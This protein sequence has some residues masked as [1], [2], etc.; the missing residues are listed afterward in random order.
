MK[1]R[2]SV[3]FA[4]VLF[5]LTAVLRADVRLAAPFGSNAVIQ[6]DK[7]IPV[8]GAADAGEKVTVQFGRRTAS[9]TTG[10]DGRWR[11]TLDALPASDKPAELIITGKNQVVFTN[12]LVGDVWLCGGQSNMEWN[13]ARTDNAAA[14]IAAA[15][16]PGIRYIKIDR[17]IASAPAA[18]ATG[19]WRLCTPRE[20]GPCSAVAYFFAR[21]INRET[22]VPIGIIQ[23]S[24]SGAMIESYMPPATLAAPAFPN[25]AA[26]WKQT[27]AAYPRNKEKYDADRAAWEKE[28]DAAAEKNSPFKKPAPREPVGI[29]H[30]DE[31][32]G[33]YN[34]MVAPLAPAGLRG[35]LWY[36]GEGNALRF[37]EYREL[38]ATMI[39]SWRATFAQGDLPFYWVQLPNYKAG[40]GTARARAFLREAQDQTLA[41]P[42]TGQA[43]TIDVGNPDDEHPT[44]KQEVGRRL[45]L[46]ALTKQYGKS[47]A[48]ENPRFVSARA[49]GSAM[50]VT[51]AHASGL[52]LRGTAAPA[53][54]VAGAD[55]VFRSATARIET[56]SGGV[57][58]LVSS[59]EVAAP[60]AVRYAWFN[61][62][63]ANLHNAAGLP[64]TPF[65]SDDWEA[66]DTSRT[67]TTAPDNKGG[68]KYFMDKH[69][70]FLARAKE[71]P[72]DLLFIGDSIT[73]GW[74]KAPEIWEKY[75]GKYNPA[76]F[77]ISGDSTQHVLWRIAQG[78]LDNVKPK[79]VVLMIGTNNT[80]TNRPAEIA[81][82]VTT[83]IR[84]I[85]EKI[86]AAK[87]LL[88]A[89]FPRGPRTTNGN[90]DDAINRMVVI[91]DVNA[92]LA[93]LADGKRVQFL[94]INKTFLGPD[95]KIP[96]DVM[97]DQL[98]PGPHGYQLWAEAMQ[99]ALEKIMAE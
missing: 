71:G 1:T 25:V 20:I 43:V 32:S 53:F 28:R 80:G 64:L 18:R 6:R 12:I 66:T 69:A 83:I 79:V 10:A 2:A 93:R 96:N 29:G 3:F 57:T 89:V 42:N 5:A 26:R 76:N 72:V 50:R 87:V 7:P 40:R 36:Q 91:N 33:I 13:V 9:A 39:T 35:F 27:L 58:L 51:L 21:D 88:L 84:R 92:R 30:R 15:N 24:W 60:V 65:R 45:A 67:S 8:W 22:G 47:V 82:G 61:D 54:E 70:A 75:Y 94:D 78:E 23:S 16:H 73:D 85:H 95:G 77:G 17:A 14:E 41:L 38:F 63:A 56:K 86:P 59:P 98:H 81:E 68:N 99:P 52:A 37:D 31:P 44:N 11:V 19:I 49:E 46:I 97:P 74:S 48:F 55:R 4:V 62:P 90:Y 34:A